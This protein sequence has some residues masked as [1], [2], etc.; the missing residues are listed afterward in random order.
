MLSYYKGIYI[1]MKI[2]HF[3]ETVKIK[4]IYFA[5]KTALI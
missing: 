5:F 3:S 1:D 4:K 2:I